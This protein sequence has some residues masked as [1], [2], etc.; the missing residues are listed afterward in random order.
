MKWVTR[1]NAKVDRIA[2]HWLIKNFIDK[3]GEL[4][5]VPKEEVL[6][7]AEKVKPFLVS[8]VKPVAYLS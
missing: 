4:L 6:S 1:K 8:L 2:C 7:T 5:F 3:E